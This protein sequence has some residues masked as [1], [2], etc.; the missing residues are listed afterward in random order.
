MSCES[1]KELISAY[2]DAELERADIL[3]VEEHIKKC[4][5]CNNILKSYQ[6]ISSRICSIEIPKPSKKV[7]ERIIIFPRRK[8][9]RLRRLAVSASLLVILGILIAPFFRS[10]ETIAQE[11]PKEYYIVKEE[12]TP[13]SEVY[14][15]REGNFVLTSYSGGSF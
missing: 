6:N 4:E 12:K 15:E 1:I 8:I 10:E 5:Y 14:Y 7:F 13:Y 11:T 2:I 9:Y 3:K